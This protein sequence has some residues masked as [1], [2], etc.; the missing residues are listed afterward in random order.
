MKRVIA[1]LTVVLTISLLFGCASPTNKEGKQQT[2][3]GGNSGLVLNTEINQKNSTVMFPSQRFSM[4]GNESAILMT[5]ELIEYSKCMRSKGIRWVAQDLSQSYEPESQMFYEFGPWTE[6]MANRFGSVK[7]MSQDE[8]FANGFIL[9]KPE[10]YD[11]RHRENPNSQISITPA[12]TKA[13]NACNKNVESR[14]TSYTYL[15]KTKPKILKDLSITNFSTVLAKNP[16]FHAIKKDLKHCYKQEGLSYEDVDSPLGFHIKGTSASV[17]NETQIQLALRDVKCKNKTNTIKRLGEL[18]ANYEA[19]FIER[20]AA[21]LQAYRSSID[22]ALS[23]AK[24]TIADNSDVI[25]K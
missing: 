3:N 6:D 13:S 20:N 8:L 7:P 12:L 24:K 17:I 9:S 25:W 21:D 16:K 10:G 22:N 18:W 23:H 5:A 14:K 11:L 19:P 15:L 4:H 1:S 2:L